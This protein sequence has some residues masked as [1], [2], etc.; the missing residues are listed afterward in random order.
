[1]SDANRLVSMIALV[2][3]GLLIAAWGAIYIWLHRND[4]LVIAD[5]QRRG[6]ITQAEVVRLTNPTWIWILA[7]VQIIIGL[8]LIVWGIFQYFVNAEEV[9]VV[10]KKALGY[11]TSP[12][13]KTVITTKT[14]NGGNSR[15]AFTTTETL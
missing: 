15:R 11:N 10:A 8:A 3:A 6:T 13:E 12:V 5:L 1:M 2:I 9:V 4:Q 7:I 14:V